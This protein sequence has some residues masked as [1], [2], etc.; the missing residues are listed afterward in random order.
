MVYCPLIVIRWGLGWYIVTMLLLI[1]PALDG[2][3]N[4]YIF[5]GSDLLIE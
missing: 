1:G 4:T 3:Y 2:R 5:R